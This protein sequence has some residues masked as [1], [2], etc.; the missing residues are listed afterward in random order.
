[1]AK[2][3]TLVKI[4]EFK[5]RTHGDDLDII[6]EWSKYKENQEETIKDQE[7]QLNDLGYDY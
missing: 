2:V 3:P 1:M 7:D 6:G 4:D 5:G